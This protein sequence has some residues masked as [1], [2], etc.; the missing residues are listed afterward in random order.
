VNVWDD[1]FQRRVWER[2]PR[3]GSKQPVVLSH[4]F[5]IKG[6]LTFGEALTVNNRNKFL[7]LMKIERTP[8]G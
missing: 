4:R 1:V 3:H 6:G 8:N 2:N 7:D 5:P